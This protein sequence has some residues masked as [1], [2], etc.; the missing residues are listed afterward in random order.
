MARLRLY[1]RLL[2]LFAVLGEGALYAAWVGLRERTGGAPLALRQ[3]LTCRF[4]RRLQGALPFTVQIHGR[5][6][7]SPVLWLAN[8]VSWVDIAMLGALRPLSFLAK[9][10]VRGWPLAGWLAQQAG[11]L[12]IRRGAGE[13]GDLGGQL[14]ERLRLGSHLVIF[15]EGTSSDGGDVLR[16]HPRLLAAAVAS[17]AALQPVAIRYRRDG[18]RDELAPFVGDDELPAHLLRLLAAER[19]GV[20]ITLLEPIASDGLSRS[21]LASRAHAAIRQ[22]VHGQPTVRAAGEALAA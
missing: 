22:V 9:A 15:P 6:P 17:G 16:F 21:E 1:G 10:E 8:H 12:F 19:A 11:T 20:E 3:R 5:L 4:M 18:A 7:E 14:A 13:A 2:R